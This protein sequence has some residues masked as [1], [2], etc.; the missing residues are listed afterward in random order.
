MCGWIYESIFS[1]YTGQKPAKSER[2]VSLFK[3]GQA[4]IINGGFR[5][6]VSWTKDG[7]ESAALHEADIN[8]NGYSGNFLSEIYRCHYRELRAFICRTFGNGP[9]EPEDVVQQAFAQFVARG[10][11]D[12]I[13]NPR[14]FLYRTAQNIIINYHRHDQTAEKYRQAVLFDNQISE[15]SD[16]ITPERVI[17]KREILKIVE[18]TIRNLSQK[19]REILLLHRLHGLSYVEIARQT[20]LS[21]TA[22]KKHVALAVAACG[23][24]LEAATDACD[25]EGS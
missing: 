13:K 24:A 9:P 14:A 4:I 22:V 12:R 20:G 21:E 3:Y 25:P 10:D 1:F 18:Q 15:T 23:A 8:T 17:L 6:S 2:A 11:L 19:R 7:I 5:L 16:D